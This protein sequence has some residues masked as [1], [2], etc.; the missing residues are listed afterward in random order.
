MSEDTMLTDSID[1]SLDNIAEA[2]RHMRPDMRKKA[3]EAA[4]LIESVV[5]KLRKENPRNPAVALGVVFAIYKLA[6]QF[7]DADKN[8]A[9]RG[10]D[11][12]IQLLS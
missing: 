6:E 12:K 10:N 2:L 5:V 1:G 8:G 4:H 11:S 9:A 7:R 3:S